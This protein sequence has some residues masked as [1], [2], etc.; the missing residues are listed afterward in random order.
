MPLYPFILL[1]AVFL[2]VLILPPLVAAYVDYRR[3]LRREANAAEH[4]D[5]QGAS[6]AVRRRDS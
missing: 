1:G 5:E 3:E 6:N 2:A 4:N